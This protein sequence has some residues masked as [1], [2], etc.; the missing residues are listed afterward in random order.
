[1]D[2]NFEDK[3]R[4]AVAQIGKT[5]ETYAAKRGLSWQLQELRKV[6]LSEQV[7]AQA[8]HLSVAEREN[9]A[10]TTDEY[11]THIKG[12]SEAIKEELVAR[13]HYE[14]AQATF[15]AL[16]SLCSLEKK[17]ISEFGG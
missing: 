5:G 12:T 6:V 13:A 1:M 9:F 14:K 2:I 11:R 4:K 17:K 10:R 7:R 8:Q 16:R 15:E 3:L